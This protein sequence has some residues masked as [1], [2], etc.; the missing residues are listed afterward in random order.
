MNNTSYFQYRLAASRVCSWDSLCCQAWSWFTTSLFAHVAQQ[1]AT[2]TCLGV[3]ERSGLR[4]PS[5]RIILAWC[6]GNNFREI[7]ICIS[8]RAL[9]GTGHARSGFRPSLSLIS[10]FCGLAFRLCKQ[11]KNLITAILKKTQ[12]AGHS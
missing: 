9:W 4:S 1:P 5:R 2:A 3:S 10:S 11:N 8:K 12:V 6:L 7:F